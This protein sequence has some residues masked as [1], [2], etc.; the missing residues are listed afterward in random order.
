MRQ[1]HQY[2]Q[3]LCRELIGDPDV[4]IE[5][6]RDNKETAKAICKLCP[7]RIECAE[8]GIMVEVFG[9]WG[10]LTTSERAR[11]ADQRRINRTKLLIMP[12]VYKR[13]NTGDDND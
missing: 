11:I 13:H 3:P 7:H 4:W 6:T 9:V 12:N 8:Y 1:P 5:E 2:E 10:G